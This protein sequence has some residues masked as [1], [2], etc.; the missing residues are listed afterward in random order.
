MG[1]RGRCWFSGTLP[2]S[3]HWGGGVQG[4]HYPTLPAST[5]SYTPLGGILDPH[6]GIL[7]Y[8]K[9]VEP[10]DYGSSDQILVLKVVGLEAGCCGD[11]ETGT[12]SEL[13]GSTWNTDP[14]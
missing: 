11:G 2:I 7:S 6:E 8:D 13:V 3:I 4:T 14:A 9:F 1:R 10:Q 5:V 12:S